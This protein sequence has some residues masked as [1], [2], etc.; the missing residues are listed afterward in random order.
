MRIRSYR[1][2]DAK[3]FV[4]LVRALAAYEKLP[5]PDGAA[6]RRLAA[7]AGRRFRLLLAE[8]DGGEVVG[9]ALWFLTYS[10]FL[11]KPTLWLEDLFVLP[12][13]RGGGA[14]T[15][16]FDAC[17]A[18]ARALGCGRMEWTALDWN[19]PAH[20]FYRKKGARHLRDWW[21]YRLSPP[22]VRPS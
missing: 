14:G 16:L 19:E 17:A 2:S 6:G 3:A 10:T 11:A 22:R 18:K 5:G 7:D 4:S 15:A 1:R 20:R 21:I 13:C 12:S 9:Y 8:D